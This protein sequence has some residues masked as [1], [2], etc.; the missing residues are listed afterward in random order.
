MPA[1]KS[2]PRRKASTTAGSLSAAK[3]LATYGPDNVHLELQSLRLRVASTLELARRQADS[4][5]LSAGRALVT[6]MQAEVK[7]ADARLRAVQSSASASVDSAEIELA[8]SLLSNFS[9][10]LRDCLEGMVDQDIYSRVTSKKMAYMSAGHMNQRCAESRL[11]TPDMMQG[12]LL[13]DMGSI[14]S[15]PISLRKNAYRTKTKDAKAKKF[16][17]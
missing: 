7:E 8:D 3:R 12:E 14:A 17:G 4:G 1:T 13:D 5:N 9:E 2:V 6:K 10:D 11:E 16:W 15:A